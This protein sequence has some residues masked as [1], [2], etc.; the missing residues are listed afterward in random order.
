MKVLVRLWK[1]QRDK[2]CQG[3]R[4]AERNRREEQ[5][6][7]SVVKR[8]LERAGVV[9]IASLQVGNGSLRRRRPG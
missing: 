8:E 3:G 1:E 6:T 4:D 7:Y 2:V 5:S 9:V